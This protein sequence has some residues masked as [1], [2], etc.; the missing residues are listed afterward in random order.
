MPFAAAVRAVPLLLTLVWG[1][2][3]SEAASAEDAWAPLPVPLVQG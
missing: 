1:T 2:L 3:C